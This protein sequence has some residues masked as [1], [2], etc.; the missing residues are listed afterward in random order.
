[1]PGPVSDDLHAVLARNAELVGTARDMGCRG[2]GSLTANE[3][4]PL[5]NIE[6]ANAELD[7][8]VKSRNSEL[9]SKSA[10]EAGQ[11]GF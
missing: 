3:S 2:L 1:V 7:A 9:D 11:A 10:R 8:R 6:K 4:W 5:E